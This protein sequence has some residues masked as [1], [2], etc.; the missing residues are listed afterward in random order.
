VTAVTP[1]ALAALA[2]LS[3]TRRGL[4]HEELVERCDRLLRVLLEMEARITPSAA[5]PSGS[6]R[7]EAIREAAQMF[8]SAELLETHAPAEVDGKPGR[9]RSAEILAGPGA[10]YTIDDRKRVEL[11]TSKNIIVHFFV[12]RGLVATAMLA[13]PGSP[14][15]IDQVKDRVRRLSRLFKFEFRFRADAPFDAIF[16]DTIDTMAQAQEVVRRPDGKL[17]AGTGRHGWSGREWLLTYASF[18]HN[19]IEAYRVAARG[20][21]ALLKG[22]LAEKDLL[23]KVLATGQRMFFTG[24][25]ERS[26]ALSQPAFK[27][28][29]TAFVDQ[30]DVKIREGKYELSNPTPE[31]VKSV[32]VRVAGFLSREV[33]E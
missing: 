23:K 11:D 10:I 29:L 2:L 19:F 9:S 13:P 16:S 26:E 33:P 15:A 25:I 4:P 32:E 20:L 12:E 17:D 18:M 31:S 1:G 3:H 28:A 21:G 24:E 5:T 6:L 8:S 22:P 27:N 7:P 14:S 30:G